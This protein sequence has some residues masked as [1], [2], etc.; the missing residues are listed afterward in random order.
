MASEAVCKYAVVFG[1]LYSH[2]GGNRF[3]SHPDLECTPS[4]LSF[5]FHFPDFVNT[6]KLLVAYSYSSSKQFAKSVFIRIIKKTE[7]QPTK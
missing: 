5:L 3:D 1:T 2:F 6:L 4:P 7:N